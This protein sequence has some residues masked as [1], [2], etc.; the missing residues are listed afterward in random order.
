MAT[1]VSSG[2]WRLIN[3]S[4]Y[5]GDHPEKKTTIVLKMTKWLSMRYGVDE[6]FM[7]DF[8]GEYEHKSIV[9]R[10]WEAWGA[11]HYILRFDEW[12]TVALLQNPKSI[13]HD[14]LQTVQVYYCA[15]EDTKERLE[16]NEFEGEVRLFGQD[17]E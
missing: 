14:A 11:L 13:D 17:A 5:F 2:E 7:I 8:P 15:D 16:Q 1:L 3:N 6:Q 4:V 12:E 9:V 10:C